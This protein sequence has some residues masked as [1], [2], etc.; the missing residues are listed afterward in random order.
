MRTEDIF[1]LLIVPI[2][3]I[4]LMA[5]V[6]SYA[7]ELPQAE[8]YRGDNIYYMGA[9]TAVHSDISPP[10]RDIQPVLGGPPRTNKDD[11]G[12]S[13]HCG[14][15]DGYDP[16][17]Q[18]SLPVE[19][20][21]GPIEMPA[22]GTTWNGFAN[23]LGYTPP[24]PVGDV[25]PDH[26]IVMANSTIAV[27][28][29]T[30]TLL[31]GPSNINSLWTGFGGD[32]ENN[33]DGDPVILYDQ[34]ADRW[35]VSQ[36]TAAGSPYYNCVC[37]STSGDPTGTWQRYAFSNGT[38]GFP[39]YPKYGIWRDG[40]YFSTRNTDTGTQGAYA[41]NRDQMIAG[42]LAPQVVT[43]VLAAGSTAYYGGDGLL[44]ADVDGDT[45]PPS[46][47]P[48]LFLGTMDNGG[49]YGAPQ[50]AINVFRFQV[51]WTTPAS[52]SFTRS[53][54]V[55]VAAFDSTFTPC[56]GGRSCI[57]QPGTANKIDILSYR[58]RPTFR[59]A[60]RNFGTHESIALNQSVSGFNSG[61]SSAIAGVRWYELRD[62]NGTPTLFQQGT[63][64]PGATDGIHRWMGSIA[65]DRVGNMGLGYSAS[66]GTVYPS[67]WYTG[68]L[69]TDPLG[70]MSQGEGSM[71][72]GLGSQ[73]GSQ[74]WGDYTSINIDPVDDCTF[75]YVNQYFTATSSTTW[76]M[77]VGSFV[78]PSCLCAVIPTAPTASA[79]VPQDNRIT[80]SWDDSATATI[81][82]YFVF[83]STVA[84][85]PYTQIATVADTSP[86]V[87]GGADY[88]YNDDS[89]SGGTRYYYSVKS[90]DGDRCTSPMSNEV[91]ALATGACLLTPTFGGATSATTPL[92]ATCT[93]D[94][95]WSSPATP[96]CTGA[97]SGVT[98]TIYRSTTT[99]FIPDPTPGTGNR[100]ASGLAASPYSDTDGL[101]TGTPYYYIVRAVDS[102][103]GAEEANIVTV[104]GTPRG[105]ASLGT[106]T[107]GAETGDP[108]MTLPSPW[109]TSTTYNRTGTYSYS[110]GASYV[111]YAC[112]ALTTP[113]LIL[114]TGPVLTYYQ[115]HSTESGYDGGRVEISTNG[116]SVWTALTPTPAYPGTITNTGNSCIWPTTTPC[117]IGNSTGY[118]TT[119]QLGT[120]DLSAYN[121]QTVL[122]RWNFS[123]D[124]SVGGSL[125]NP[126]W[127]IDDIN[128]TNV[129]VPG[130]C[131]TGGGCTAPG[132]PTLVSATGTCDSV[133]LAWSAGTGTTSAYNIYRKAAPCGGSYSKIAGPVAGTTYS[134]SSAVAGTSYAYAVRGA[135]DEGAITE[136]P[137][138]NCLPAA[139]LASPTPT[140]AGAAANACPAESVELS[141]DGGLSG[142]QWNRDG[143]PI[144]GANAN[145]YDATQS[146]DY[147]V[148]YTGPSGCSG[149][150][151]S[152]SVTITPC[153]TVVQFDSGLSPASTLVELCGNGDSVVE[154]GERWSA[155]VRL[156]NT[157]N[158][159]AHSVV[160]S[161]TVNPGSGASAAVTG[162]PATFGTLA[163]GGGTG[164]ASFQFE[165]SSSTI[166]IASLTFD[167]TGLASEEEPSYPDQAPAFS[168]Q[169]GTSTPGQ[170]E[171]GAQQTTPL[172]ATGDSATSLFTPDFTIVSP[173]TASLSYS[174]AYTPTS[175][176][177]T[178][179]SDEFTTDPSLN[180]WTESGNVTSST[181]T[182]TDTCSGGGTN[183]ANFG[184]GNTTPGNS[185]RRVVDTT[186][187][188]A[189]T[190]VMDYYYTGMDNGE[191]IFVDYST[192]GVNGTF[193]NLWSK[194]SASNNSSTVWADDCARTIVFPSTCE[195]NANFALRIRSTSNQP[196][197]VSRV[198]HLRVEGATAGT[199]SFTAN[200]KVELLDGANAATVLKDFGTADANPYSVK[201]AYTGPGTYKIRLTE[202]AGGTA[203][204]TGSTLNVV[205]N[206]VTHCTVANCIGAP[207]PKEASPS[208]SPLTGTKGAGSAVD[209]LY[210]PGCGTTDHVIY[211][212][213]TASQT[214]VGIS[215]ANAACGRGNSGSTSFDPG[216]LVGGE[217]VYFLVVGQNG[218]KEG[219]YGQDF[220]GGIAH[221]RAEANNAMWPCNR[222]QDLSGTCP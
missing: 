144:P 184:G 119:W 20:G 122:L 59:A 4:T 1:Y 168:V 173:D 151:A 95:A 91:N 85:G 222:P 192:A 81:T 22:P 189:I 58:Q 188:T 9:T 170:N 128:I 99:P 210:T 19:S 6:A 206:A 15:I 138:S 161:L 220:I 190:L 115:I 103:S 110:T 202:N 113:S 27:Y 140:I 12:P 68:R 171:S 38:N 174:F 177:S 17:A 71:V 121:D 80:V 86:G 157:G 101:V 5:G 187:K 204:L 176:V 117:Y 50:D 40:Y 100:I 76:R 102:I 180:G 3:W 82:Q 31:W 172:S 41:L 46:G 24:D 107:A 105:P 179:F 118:P 201:A 84:G 120:I 8:E 198:D 32:C 146:G 196:A 142:Y 104:S 88:T 28:T 73:T 134:D 64:V 136:S 175:T 16:V 18:T 30:G 153:I 137:D 33:N 61:T 139:R 42:N 221:E 98:Y 197:E 214:L 213:K 141:T 207:N 129:M 154:P 164:T 94:V 89:V 130:I 69:A 72:D 111:H 181:T 147:T 193:T 152:K 148:S 163:L 78:F 199:E 74:R 67:V 51:N 37:L 127:Y 208:G 178:L 90:N 87:G 39:D 183:Y 26:Y 21:E 124:G 159:D 143:S 44:P 2:L 211:W 200:A 52:S 45:L 133:D 108:T 194:T 53:A 116:G 185:I 106:F 167:V 155:S 70:T 83:R 135:C 34:F 11:P 209:V 158:T 125:A 165:V 57:P 25:G 97:G 203:T 186:G 212:T 149:T 191:G 7:Q 218:S 79:S 109:G 166:C 92:S 93:L 150:S 13:T 195:N 54:T 29:K 123:T 66:S 216:A 205:K 55:P 23:V 162:N 62:P 56:A 48:E 126:G 10:L 36:F 96:G 160:G 131:T 77:R 112:G 217:W 75:W 169:V 65:M 47:S 156:K 60:Y 63:F 43:F 219:S 215:W 145:T 14:P 114:G 182:P 49:P 132:A 35:L